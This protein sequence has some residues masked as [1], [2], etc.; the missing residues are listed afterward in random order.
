[1]HRSNIL[2]Q[3]AGCLLLLLAGCH[4][5]DP[6]EALT[7]TRQKLQQAATISYSYLG[8]WPNPVGKIDTMRGEFAIQW[9]TAAHPLQYRYIGR[10]ITSEDLY[11]SGDSFQRINHQ[12][13][14]VYLYTPA[15]IEKEKTFIRQNLFTV[16]SPINM[17]ELPDWQYAQD[18]LLAGK[19]LSGYRMVEM[20]TTIDEKK[21]FVEKYLFIDATQMLP[22]RYERR[23]YLNGV[24][25]Q[26]II[27]TYSD[28][29][30]SQQEQSLVYELPSDY[31]S[32]TY[33]QQVEKQQL[34]ESGQAAP[35]IA[36]TDINGHP[37]QL[38][39]LRGKK[40]LLDFSVINCGYCKLALEHLNDPD[41]QLNS[42]IA[43]I[44]INP[45][46]DGA[47]MHDYVDKLPVP[48]PVIADAK[49]LGKNYGVWAYPTFFLIDEQGIIE[50]VVVGYDKIFLESLNNTGI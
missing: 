38:K 16:Y 50:K 21:I 2:L 44:Y 41:F 11:F 29:K 12:D 17:L 1:M 24:S 4:T 42:N 7:G 32:Q 28:F 30:L 5:A 3:L 33:G 6:M 18:T 43:G 9:D 20:D 47:A 40:V 25:S 19:T 22:V 39:D 13:S 26:T 48:F 37:V 46:D 49:Q 35:D 8:L 23:A 45:A 27:Y 14:M 15:D 36:A 10:N 31:R 34:L